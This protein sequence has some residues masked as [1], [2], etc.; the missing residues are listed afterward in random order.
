MASASDT[1][2]QV[3]IA[4]CANHERGPAFLEPIPHALFW[5]AL[6]AWIL[7]LIGMWVR[8]LRRRPAQR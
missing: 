7:T 2:P 3:V 5:I 6:L 8:L 1:V 4:E